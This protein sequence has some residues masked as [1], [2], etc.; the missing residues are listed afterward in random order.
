MVLLLMIFVNLQ[1]PPEDAVVTMCAHVF[2]YQCVSEYLR[3]DEN[4]CPSYECKELLGHDVVFSKDTLRSCL[5][6]N[7]HHDFGPS[8]EKPLVLQ[9]G[10]RS[11]K[12]KAAMEILQSHCKSNNACSQL[13]NI[14][15]HSD[16]SS[17]R[18]KET[19]ESVGSIVEFTNT[20]ALSERDKAVKE[21][22]NDPEVGLLPLVGADLVL[23]YH[24]DVFARYLV[25][26]LMH[27]FDF[28][29]ILVISCIK[30]WFS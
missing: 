12:V 17:S 6:G 18:G 13:H 7:D 26:G 9:K 25:V 14:V 27:F 30:Y 19:A 20:K 3:G 8:S 5:H 28:V 15:G 11:S 21:F 16:I 22:N 23:L 4:T 10:Y 2:C 1:D 24:I 29:A